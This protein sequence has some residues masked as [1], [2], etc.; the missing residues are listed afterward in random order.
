MNVEKYFNTFIKVK[1]DSSLKVMQYFMKKYNNIQNEM[2]I[3]HVAGTN[4]KG[5]CVEMISKIL[6]EEGY[7]VGKFISPHLMK[8]NERISIN[9]NLITDT[10]FEELI[11]ELDPIIREYNIENNTNVI[12]FELITIM[13]LIYFYRKKVDFVVLETGIGGLYDCTNVIEKP[14]V[15]VVTSIGYDHTN[16]LGNSLKEIASQKAGII[17]QNSN[18]VY[19]EQSEEINNVFKEKCLSLN[20]KLHLVINDDIK[21]YTYDETYQYFD[22]KQYKNILLKLKG[23]MQIQNAALCIETVEAIKEMGYS[24]SEAST[25][26]GLKDVEHKGRMEILNKEPLVIYDGAHNEPA[27]INL[28]NTVKMYYSGHKRTYIVSILKKKD[29]KKVVEELLKDEEAEFIFTSGN[30]SEKFV[31]KE[32]IYEYVTNLKKKKNQKLIMKDLE[33]AVE[34]ALTHKNSKNVYFV[35]GSFYVY[36]TVNNEI[37]KVKGKV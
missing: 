20:N 36:E 7:K 19:F 11:R 37:Y 18:T 26:K 33:K 34:D 24:I 21:N 32:E 27:V 10:E 23:K 30:D 9:G 28:L 12:F 6:E 22:Y 35:V 29:Y 5:S 14:L 31:S 8:Y 17:K 15:S 3:I 1:H 16:V 25:R 2:K 4:G 13:A